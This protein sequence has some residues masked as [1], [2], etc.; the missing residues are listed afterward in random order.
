MSDLRMADV[1]EGI[2]E[3]IKPR[4]QRALEWFRSLFARVAWKLWGKRRSIR[5]M[6]LLA[7]VPPQFP[8]VRDPESEVRRIVEYREKL[9]SIHVPLPTPDT[10]DVN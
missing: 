6:Q 8:N 4:H 3:E 2:R 1:I 9:D 7:F 5:R 10:H